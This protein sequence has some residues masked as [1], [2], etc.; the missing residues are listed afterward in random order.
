MNFNKYKIKGPSVSVEPHEIFLDKMAQSEEE[1]TGLSEKKFE[2]PLREGVSY[3]LFGIFFVLASLLFFKVFYFQFFEGKSLSIQA[4]NNKGSMSLIVPER[5][6]IYD[7]NMKKLVLNS[8]AYDL[9]CDRAHFSF[10]SLDI[11]NQIKNI[12]EVAGMN[13]DE[14]AEKIQ[15]TDSTDV[16]M[17]DVID[18]EKLLVL[19][20]RIGG[21]LGCRILQNTA[22]EYVYGPVFSQVLGYIGRINKDEYSN[23]KGYV[24]NDYIGRTGLEKYYESYL[25]GEPGKSKSIRSAVG[26]QSSSQIVVPPESGNNLVLN[27]DANLQKLLYDSLG[28]NLKKMGAQKGAAVAMDP[29]TGAILGLA[30]YPSYDDNLFSG[31]ISQQEYGAL[32]DDPNQPFF[33]R[34]I[35]AQYSTGSIIKP[36][37]ASA[38][39]QENLI[40]PLKKIN[41][42]GYIL[43]QSQ[44]D[45]DVVYRYGGVMPHGLVDMREAIA[46]S[47]NIYFY[48]IG[49]GYGDQQGLGPTRIKKY[50]S[51]FGWNEKTGIDL[52][53]EFSGFIPDPAWKK[54]KK[55]SS[56][57]DGDTYNLAIGQSDLRTTPLQVATAYSAI[58]NGGTLYK[59]QIVNRIISGMG[60]SVA[61]VREFEPEIIRSGFIDPQNLQI[62]REGMKAGV[63]DDHG[64]S[65][66]LRDLPITVAAKTGTAEI[67][68]KDKFNVWSSVFAPYDNTEIVLVVIAE[69]IDGVG[70]VTLPVAHD[71]LQ[72]YFSDR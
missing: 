3:F 32:Q 45:P 26:I 24:I 40:S 8:P 25:R 16:L 68:Y 2:V 49:G 51:L 15:K 13:S 4:E 54:E 1:A 22:R 58:A 19:E 47:S 35:Q 27:I 7:K 37:E 38:A 52:P 62:V 6:I 12:A 29:R 48:T 5:G 34:A 21:M 18:H 23:N 31:G 43:V 36:L 50:L 59:P 39:L 57:V 67:G 63:Y 28:E 20:T 60:D 46:V 11:S 9:I 56:W 69:G 66:R 42:P 65:A 64:T 10:S 44:Y 61:T 33:N 72:W 17:V 71:V 70:A 30:S 14:V 41:D 53:G 55:G